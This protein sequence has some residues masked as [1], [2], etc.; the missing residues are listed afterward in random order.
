MSNCLGCLSFSCSFKGWD[1][2]LGEEIFFC[3]NPKCYLD[4]ISIKHSFVQITESKAKEPRENKHLDYFE[5]VK[6]S[7]LSKN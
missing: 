4:Y 7:P 2:V 1:D 3:A 6:V 5:K